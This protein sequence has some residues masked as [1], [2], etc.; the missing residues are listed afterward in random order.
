MK[1]LSV[2]T[3]AVVVTAALSGA[4]GTGASFVGNH[5]EDRHVD[6]RV[7]APG[8]GWRQVHLETSNISWLNDDTG[9]GLLV[10]SHCE[11]VQDSP[12]EGLTGELL[13]GTTERE[14]LEQTVRPWAGREAMETIATGKLDGVARKRALFVVKKDGC[15]Y[16]VVYDAPLARFDAGYAAYVAVRDGFSIAARRDR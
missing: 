3:A 10:N 16:D 14:V 11:G 13:I 15:V 1:F 4:C 8:P 6:Y 5:F 2:T 7:G 12:L 9:A